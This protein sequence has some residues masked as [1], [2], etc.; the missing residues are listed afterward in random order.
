MEKRDILMTL[1]FNTTMFKNIDQVREEVEDS[2]EYYGM[3]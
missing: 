3:E 2:I 1:S